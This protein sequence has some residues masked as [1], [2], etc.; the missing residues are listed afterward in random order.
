MSKPPKPPS[1]A[2]G[3]AVPDLNG[4]DWADQYL[5]QRPSGIDPTLIAERLGWTPAQRLEALPQFV[6]FLASVPPRH[7]R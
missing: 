7:G 6:D 1:A 4:L 3:S 5:A 2:P